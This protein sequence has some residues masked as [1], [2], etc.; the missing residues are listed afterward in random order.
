MVHVPVKISEG[1]REEIGETNCGVRVILWGGEF[2]T[3]L[4]L[5][6]ML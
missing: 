5:D 4:I 1:V 6:F 2:S 3:Y